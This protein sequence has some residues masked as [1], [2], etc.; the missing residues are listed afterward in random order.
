MVHIFCH[1]CDA[2]RETTENELICSQCSSTFVET[3]SSPSQSPAVEEP[4]V[5]D[6]SEIRED[7]LNQNISHGISS[8][9]H[10]VVHDLIHNP[11]QTHRMHPNTEISVILHNIPSVEHL[12]FLSSNLNSRTTD[13][14][15]LMHQLMQ[16]NPGSRGSPPASSI[17]VSKL[18]QNKRLVRKDEAGEC[19]VCKDVWKEGQELVEIGCG[20]RYCE[21]CIVPWLKR[22]NSCPVCR[23]ELPTDD[24]DYEAMKAL[25]RRRVEQTQREEQIT[26]E[27][28]VID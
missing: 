13:F 14:D 12:N 24:K 11:N 27:E 7:I 15:N 1:H 5:S 9:V 22:H 26:T 28:D 23:F 19:A 20:H 10:H 25:E 21:E 3:I 8:V 16:I 4:P 17:E 2:Q 18:L 6:L